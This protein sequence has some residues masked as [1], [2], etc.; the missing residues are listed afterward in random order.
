MCEYLAFWPQ[1]NQDTIALT[2]RITFI[3]SIFTQFTESAS[4]TSTVLIRKEGV[5]ACEDDL[6][7]ILSLDVSI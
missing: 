7:T 5:T 4:V 6:D 2:F 3:T 1:A